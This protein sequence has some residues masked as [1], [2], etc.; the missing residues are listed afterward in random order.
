MS[1]SGVHAQPGG[2]V[3]VKA[4][5]KGLHIRPRSPW[6]FL[7]EDWVVGLSALWLLVVGLIGAGQLGSGS[8]PLGAALLLAGII[9]GIPALIQVVVE[10]IGYVVF[11]ALL[12]I[13]VIG[14]P[15]LFFRP[16]RRFLGKLWRKPLKD[17][18]LMPAGAIAE[19][20]VHPGP[21]VD[22]IRVDGGGVR[23]SAS[24]KAGER[25]TAEVAK[26]R[27]AGVRGV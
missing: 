8:A 9:G 4:S 20:R 13:L 2:R 6:D 19:V 7:L 26:L 18:H 17:R 14:F 15:L 1:V 22:V 21:V 24:G 16:V 12:P 10:V 3:R 27:S 11:L 5:T 25:L 23:L